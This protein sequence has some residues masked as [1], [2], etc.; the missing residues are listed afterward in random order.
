MGGCYLS[1]VGMVHLGVCHTRSKYM[2]YDFHKD[3]SKLN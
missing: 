3:Y 1:M 2:C